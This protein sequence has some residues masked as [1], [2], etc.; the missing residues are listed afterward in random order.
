M[1]TNGRFIKL[2]LEKQP[3]LCNNR[4]ASLVY[5]ILFGQASILFLGDFNFLSHKP[6]E[7]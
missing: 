5:P 2:H 6:Y 4:D 7:I 3:V 1:K